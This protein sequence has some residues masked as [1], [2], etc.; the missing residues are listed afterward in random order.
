M[1]IYTKPVS[2]LVTSD[3]EE[4]LRDQAV[5]NIRLEF[6]REV[7]AKDETLKKLS[8]FANTFGGLLVVGASAR[9][10]DGRIETLPGVDVQDG[11]KQKVVDWCFGGASPP[12][13]V[14]VSDPIPTPDG[15]GKVCYVISVPEGDVAP[16]FLNGRKG[17]WIR[18]DEFSG[19]F[20][21]QLANESEL[22]SLL[23][24]RKMIL[25][26][27]QAFLNAQKGD[28]T[29]TPIGHTETR[30]V[31]GWFLVRVLSCALSRAF[32][33][34]PSA[35]RDNSSRSSGR[36]ASSGGGYCSPTRGAALSR[37]MR[38]QLF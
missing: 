2:Q 3:L 23:D 37:S 20:D 35:S 12:L 1:P 38:A 18:T 8:S 19:R 4:L 29:S 30:L 36:L 9:S 17:V 32:Q 24:R 5:E 34:V 16:H 15:S 28:L 14:E 33:R 11:Y 10:A 22:R 7:P 6:K 25:E 26:A 21:A 13:T 27:G 31:I